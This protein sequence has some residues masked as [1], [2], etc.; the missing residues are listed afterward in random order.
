MLLALGHPD[1]AMF[2]FD[3]ALER[4]PRRLSALNDRGALR[5]R[6]GDAKGAVEDFSRVIALDSLVWSAYSNRALAWSK[7]GEYEQAVSDGRRA[8]AVDPANPANADVLAQ[9]GEDLFRM[10]RPQEAVEAYT[11]AIALAR[12]ERGAGYYMG[13]SRA[14]AAGGDRAR[15]ADD[16]REAER[17]EANPARSR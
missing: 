9:V 4:D 10:G 17:L 8:V 1:S 7:L 11:R 16:Q 14:W 2:Y 12:P 6:R 13:R 3:R 5:L 15:A